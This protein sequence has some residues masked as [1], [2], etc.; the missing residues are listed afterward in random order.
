MPLNI[1]GDA[2]LS[3]QDTATCF[4]THYVCAMLVIPKKKKQSPWP[5]GHKPSP[6]GRLVVTAKGDMAHFQTCKQ[7]AQA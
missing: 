3:W 4:Y 7:M 5:A 2:L 6:C 1:F